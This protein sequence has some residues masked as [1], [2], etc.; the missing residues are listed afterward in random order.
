MYSSAHEYINQNAVSPEVPNIIV[1]LR[2]IYIQTQHHVPVNEGEV[3]DA[4]RQAYEEGSGKSMSASSMGSAA[5]LQVRMPA[6]NWM[7]C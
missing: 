6:L 5:A 4:H 2:L 1:Y 3:Q 7:H